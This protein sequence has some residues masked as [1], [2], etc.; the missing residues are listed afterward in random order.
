MTIECPRCQHK[1]PD[2]TAFCGKC[3]TKFDT[4]VRLTRTLETSKEE[5]T[6]GSTFAGRYRII[7]ELG[8]GGMGKVYKVLDI[9]TKEKIALKLIKPEIASD[10]KTIERFRNELTTARK[11]GHRNVCRMYDLNKENDTYYITMEYV[12]GGDLKKFI[13]RSK[14]LDTSTVIFFAKQICEGLEE[15]HNLGIVHRDLKPNN[16]MIDD[17]GIARIMDFGIARTVKGRSITGSG[18]MIGTPEYMSPEQ[19]EAKDIDQRSD[20]YSLGIIMYEMLTGRLPFEADTPFAVGIKHQ[21]EIPKNPK[22]LNPLIPDDL[23]EV[24]LKCL[25]KDRNNRYQSPREIIS[26]LARIEE[27][28]PTPD[29]PVSKKKTLTS[30][31]ITVK[32]N[33]K[34]S[35]MPIFIVAAI[36]VV[37]AVIWSPWK[38]RE[39]TSVPS[40]KPSIAVLAFEDLSPQKDQGYFC[41]GF[42]ESLIN[43]LT[44]IE[45]LRIPAR[46]SSFSFKDKEIDIQEIGKTLS[47]ETVLQGSVQKSG[48]IIRITTQLINVADGSILWS[49]QY[50]REFEDVFTIQDE[51]TMSIVDKLK[52]SLLSEE[53]EDLTKRYTKNFEAYNLYLKGRFH[54]NK[55]NEEEVKIGINYFQE[56]I[57][58]DPAYAV[59]YSGLAD[60]YNALGFYSA[61]PP[62]EAFPKAKA[63]AQKAIEIDETLA[64]AH[65]SLAYASMYYDWDWSSTDREFKRAQELNASYPTTPHWHAEYLAAMGRLEEAIAEKKRASQLDPLSMIINTTVGWMYYFSG[66]YNQAIAQI[67]ETLEIDPNFF[68]AHFWLAQAYEQKGML[69]EAI[70]ESQKAV[71]L[72]GNST[73]TETSLAHVFAAS[74]D[75]AKAKELLEHLKQLSTE[76]YV[77]AYEIAEVYVGLGENDLAFYWLQKAF[78]ERSR[79]LIFLKV[80]PRLD[81]IRSDPRFNALL[82]KMNLD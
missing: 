45:N 43:T 53:K 24:V 52:V 40:D 51:I 54:W 50:N 3:G 36:V 58:K 55:R 49:E 20:I 56:A 61:L 80:E 44:K 57:D 17:N 29:R 77:S 39:R 2:E 9:E 6:T 66:Q 28:L 34:K 14:R 22:E 65:T 37:G 73:F 31:E 4:K 48:N 47:V 59:A 67:T 68:P 46:A 75:T 11:I 79:A 5:L 23:S 8:K 13:R 41:D 76:R 35:F 38:K 78:D 72:S 62:N 69:Q 60:C 71:T 16:I 26:E 7:E 25:E 64:E 21:S 70:L 19:V 63:A 12:S 30:R 18:V 1:N 10:K 82:K 32:F 74:G 42:A 33:M 15:A 27:G 81:S